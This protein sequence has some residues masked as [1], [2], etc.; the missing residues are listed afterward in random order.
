MKILYV[1][2]EHYRTHDF[3]PN[4]ELLES[5]SD[6]FSSTLLY[7][8]LWNI[9]SCQFYIGREG[10]CDVNDH[11]KLPTQYFGSIHNDEIV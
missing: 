11:F 8:Y 5:L 1:P 9:K 7:L 10:L 2:F 3:F 6:F 4:C